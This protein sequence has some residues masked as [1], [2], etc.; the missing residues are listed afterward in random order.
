M[1]SIDLQASGGLTSWI[2]TY[3]DNTWT[4][5]NAAYK[6]ANGNTFCK[7][8]GIQVGNYTQTQYILNNNKCIYGY[9]CNNTMMTVYQ[10]NTCQTALNYF[11]V[12]ENGV[13]NYQSIL[14]NVSVSLY[15]FTGAKNYIS[16]YAYAPGYE[17]ALSTGSSIEQ[18]A[19]F[20]FAVSILI[21]LCV[22]VY[23]LPRKK[24]LIITMVSICFARTVTFVAYSYAQFPTVLSLTWTSFILD[25]AKIYFLLGNYVTCVMMSKIF[26]IKNDPKRFVLY[27]FVTLAYAGLECMVWYQDVMEILPVLLLFLKIV[28]QQ[29]KTRIKEGL[30]SSISAMIIQYWRMV[31]IM[32]L[33]MC[34]GITHLLLNY[35]SNSTTLLGSDKTV[36]SMSAV[37][38]LIQNNHNLLIIIL[39]EY[40]CVF[41]WEL[42][43][44]KSIEPAPVKHVMLLDLVKQPSNNVE[45]TA[46]MSGTVEMK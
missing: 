44:P 8:E 26:N 42:V 23:Y 21:S 15:Q 29:K 46:I 28:G 2:N 13:N 6:M 16:W 3:L 14:G 7:M 17:F 30:D 5:T 25:I 45:G 27:G 4:E 12:N 24:W 43:Q 32:I 41:T 22:W 38:L 40:L 35:I 10:E 11:A 33:Q 31:L 37:F 20:C 1:S 36:L 9:T 19:I 34:A 18:F 39:Y